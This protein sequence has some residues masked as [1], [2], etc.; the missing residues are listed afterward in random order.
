MLGLGAGRPGGRRFR[1]ELGELGN[2]AAGVARLRDLVARS[3][4]LYGGADAARAA[5]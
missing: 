2:D 1:R 5:A 4:P 3:A